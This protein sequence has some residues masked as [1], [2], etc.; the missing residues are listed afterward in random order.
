MER[1]L[2]LRLQACGCTVEARVNDIAVARCAPGQ[3]TV[4]TPVHEY[5][6]E[7]DNLLSLVIE[8]CAPGATPAPRLTGEPWA[9]RLTLVLPRIDHVGSEDSA[10][11]VAELDWALPAGEIVQPPL[12]VTRRVTLPIRFPRW[13]WLDLP[14]HAESP[15]A[16]TAAATFVQGLAIA[17]ARADADTWLRATRL[18][19]EDLSVAYR[20]DPAAM[21]ERWRAR[22]RLLQ[23][24]GALQV[25]LPAIADIRLRSCAGGRLLDCVDAAGDPVLRTA[26]DADGTVR[27]WP[28]RV[29]VIDGQCHVLR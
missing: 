25:R 1:L 29:A 15:A 26:P 23:A 2:L 16:Q 22:L 12:D 5:V 20:L 10:R 21:A 4:S 19:L 24:T 17:L 8:P 13:R 27:L 18:R 9:A 28:V 6:V 3:G 14:R 11:T 7:G